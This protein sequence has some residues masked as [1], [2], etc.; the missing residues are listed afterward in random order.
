MRRIT[1]FNIVP[2]MV[3][4]IKI[5]EKIRKYLIARKEFLDFANKNDDLIGN[6][7][8]IGRIGEYIAINFY[9]EK[10][11][12]PIR[13]KTSNN[14]TFD[15][16]V[17]RKYVSVKII[18]S[19]NKKGKTT[20]ISDKKNNSWDEVLIILLNEEYKVYKIGLLKRKIFEEEK[21]KGNYKNKRFIADRK[22]FDP[23]G[24][25]EQFGEVWSGKAV[26]RYL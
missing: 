8:I 17:N 7:N 13:A 22:L 3:Y 16:I 14:P 24:I 4:K 26:E 10:G 11:L 18:T 5:K 19:E 21:K 9:K 2:Y 23:N 15:L 20:E 6:D 1:V 12:K 25:F